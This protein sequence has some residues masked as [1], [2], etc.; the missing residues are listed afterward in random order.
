MPYVKGGNAA[1]LLKFLDM[2][3]LSQSGGVD[4]AHFSVGFASPNF[5]L[6][7]APHHLELLE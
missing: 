1:A 6:D 5:F 4:Y 2:L 7:Y 3:T